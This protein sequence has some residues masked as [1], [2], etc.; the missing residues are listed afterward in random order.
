MKALSVMEPWATLIIRYG[1]TTENRSWGTSHRGP[2]LI[3]AS[4][5]V[6]LEKDDH[7][8]NCYQESWLDLYDYYTCPPHGKAVADLPESFNALNINPGYAIGIVDV[9]GCDTVTRT[10]WDAYEQYHWRLANARPIDPFPVR[11]QLG[12]FDA[13]YN[14]RTGT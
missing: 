2:L 1:K 13:N 8:E 4:K 11:G 6:D 9:I 10:V 7:P 14:E 5:K 12:L 3:C